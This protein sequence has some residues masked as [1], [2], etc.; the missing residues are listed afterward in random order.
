[1]GIRGRT[2]L[3]CF[4]VAVFILGLSNPGQS[5]WIDEFGTWRLT[6]ASSWPAWLHQLR[7][8]P[9]SDAQIPLYH[10]YMRVWTCLF[11]TSEWSLRAANLPW[12]LLALY[13]LIT[14]PLP[15]SAE[16]R[17]QWM[18]LALILHPMVW[19]YMAEVRPYIMLLAG[20]SIAASGILV[21]LLAEPGT[22]CTRG[23]APRLLAGIALMVATSALGVIWSLTYCLWA[24]YLLC[25]PDRPRFFLWRHLLVAL[26]LLLLISPVLYQ[27]VD[28]F[29][30]G[31][32]A[33][34]T[35]EPKLANFIYAAYELLGLSGLG[36]GREQLRVSVVTALVPYAFA[37]LPT[38]L[39]LSGLLFVGVWRWGRGIGRRSCLG[40]LVLLLPVAV[41]YALGQ[42]KHWRVVGR[43]MMPML[44][45]IS[46]FWGIALDWLWRQGGRLRW[47]GPLALLLLSL[48][49][50]WVTHADRH[51]R[52]DYRDAAALAVSEV[53]R[54]SHVWWVADYGGANYYDLAVVLPTQCKTGCT[55][56]AVYL[57][58][59]RVGDL[60]GLPRPDVIVMSRE[61][62]FDGN[63]VVQNMIKQGAYTLRRQWLGFTV[64]QAA[65]YVGSGARP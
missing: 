51:L 54:G 48:S 53:A 12:L 29:L 57:E 36:P 22:A 43:H 24:L 31:V 52:E 19:Y 18:M 45:F 46:A 13:S 16:K 40:L 9:N 35:H 60:Q 39:I 58:N 28:S 7:Y 10:L 61:E 17:R 49:A 3:L 11:S 63:G 41:L 6:I 65:G 23:S 14:A 32:S 34:A 55:G 56:H 62:T 27:Y 26:L 44:I 38:L 59:P 21:Q 4:V 30:R 5:L 64:W 37:V 50:F 25:K 2:L 8:W 1:M 33:T 42:L 47:M 15:E 20:A